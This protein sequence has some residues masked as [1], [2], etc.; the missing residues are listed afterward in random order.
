MAD[1]HFKGHVFNP[2][3]LGEEVELDVA[4]RKEILFAEEQAAR[5][6][7]Y[8][9]LGLPW[10]AG[11]DA[12]RAAY[13]ARVKTFHPDRYPGKRLGSYRGRLERVFKRLTEAK[14]VLCDEAR[15]RT[16][17]EQSAPPEERRKAE[18]RRAEEEKRADERRARLAR[19]NPLVGQSVQRAQR[20]TELL[21]RG[22][23]AAAEGRFAAAANDFFTVLGIDANHA[24]ARALGN[25]ARAK[26][27]AAKAN[28]ALERAVKASLGGQRESAVEALRAAVEAEPANAKTLL[29]A[30]RVAADCG[31]WEAARQFSEAAVRVAPRS[32]GAAEALGVALEALGRKDEARRA[33]ERAVELDP[34]LATA[35]E[36]LKKMK[37][38]L[39]FLR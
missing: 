21:Q 34:Q 28:E 26:A 31:A 18:L 36:R 19:S 12:A 20:V 30:S 37:G 1:D 2:A 22:K 23:Q 25:D 15:R 6:T 33:L 13:V 35:R 17:Q 8:D 29:R 16:Y 7:L 27:N 39:G 38:L 10:G 32:G 4:L 24:E 5:G 3:D 9:V 14:D 11:G